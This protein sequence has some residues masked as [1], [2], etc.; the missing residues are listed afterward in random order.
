MVY[1]RLAEEWID[2]GGANHAAGDM[3]DVDCCTLAE[4]ES[5]GIVATPGEAI[6]TFRAGGQ[7]DLRTAPGTPL[8]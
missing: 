2:G 5:Q 8:A 3:I 1:V 4:L 6:P 7:P